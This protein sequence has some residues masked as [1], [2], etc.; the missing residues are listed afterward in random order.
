MAAERWARIQDLA[1]IL[2]L[3][4]LIGLLA[5]AATWFIWY[6][7]A[8][9]CLPETAALHHCNPE[10]LARYINVEIWGRCLTLGSISGG[11]IGGG[12]NYGMFSR[13]RAARMAAEMM[14]AEE[15]KRAETALAEERK[16]TDEARQRADEA[17]QHADE[18]R[19]RADEERQRADTLMM[20]TIQ[21]LMSDMAEMRAELSELRR[22]RN[23]G[24]SNGA[25]GERDV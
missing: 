1:E 22:Q 18:A 10:R 13:E 24:N 14:L 5:A 6:Y 9:P 16:R 11:L 21:T 4:L 12:V 20:Q 2:W 7:T 3:P 8:V 19:Q 17:R 15:R 23:N 25:H